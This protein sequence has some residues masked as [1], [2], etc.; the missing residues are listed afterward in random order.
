MWIYLL[1]GPPF[2]QPITG[3]LDITP[4]RHAA[5]EMTVG[6]R[7]LACAVCGVDPKKEVEAGGERGRKK[8]WGELP[9]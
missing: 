1:W 7:G 4:R 6:S 3:V 9:W 8:P 5:R 2:I